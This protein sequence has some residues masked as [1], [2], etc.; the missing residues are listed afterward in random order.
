MISS[1]LGF[2]VG[3]TLGLTGAGGGILAVPALVLGVGLSMTAAAPIALIAVG[4]AAL[5]GAIDGLRRHM[6]RYKAA[7]IMSVTGG[8]VSPLGVSLAK[9]LPEFWL[10]LLFVG[11]MFIVAL[12]MFKQNLGSPNQSEKALRHNKPCMV[13][14][15]TGKFI[16]NSSCF[17]TIISIGAFSGLLTGLLGVGGG[18]IIVPLLQR[19][20]NLKIHSIVA[21]SLMVIALISTITVFHALASS[22]TLHP[23]TWPFVGFVVAG[24]VAGRF[25]APKLTASTIQIGFAILCSISAIVV[26]C[27]AFGCI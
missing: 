20:T 26:L 17:I 21:T 10:K 4:L 5:T 3:S 27:N 6:V 14:E 19:F 22:S 16:W 12:R 8:L 25:I 2:I 23:A 7:L 13:S 1:V 9:Q 18:F 11:V 24:M 15:Q